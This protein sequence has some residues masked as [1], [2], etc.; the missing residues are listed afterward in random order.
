MEEI[1]IDTVTEFKKRP[2]DVRAHQAAIIEAE[3][4]A[5]EALVKTA[6]AI[7]VSTPAIQQLGLSV[8]HPSVQRM[9][10][11]IKTAMSTAADLPLQISECHREALRLTEISQLQ[12]EM[13]GGIPKRDDG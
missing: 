5:L 2:V 6:N 9:L 12:V 10:E 4:S 3:N 11:R 7:A 1:I 13:T 8:C